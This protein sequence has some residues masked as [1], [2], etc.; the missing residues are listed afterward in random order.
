MTKRPRGRTLVLSI[1]IGA[2]AG[3]VLAAAL[4]DALWDVI[5]FSAVGAVFGAIAGIY[6]TF[7]NWWF[8]KHPDAEVDEGSLE[9]TG[10]DRWA[11]R[12]VRALLPLIDEDRGATVGFE[13]DFPRD[14]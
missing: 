6:I 5:G 12:N 11:R 1:L 3:A 2:I 10:H 13:R 7:V 14:A 9:W 4:G 8:D